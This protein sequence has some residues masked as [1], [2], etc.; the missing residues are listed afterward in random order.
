M[1]G[2]AK[3]TKIKGGKDVIKKMDENYLQSLLTIARSFKTIE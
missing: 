3:T 1:D 2:T